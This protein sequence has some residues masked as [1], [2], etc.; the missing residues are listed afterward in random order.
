VAG[1][2]PRV[3][4]LRSHDAHDL[5]V[6]ENVQIT[7]GVAPGRQVR[8]RAPFQRDLGEPRRGG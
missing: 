2:E 4:G 6:W 3:D 8:C 7:D 1:P 5:P